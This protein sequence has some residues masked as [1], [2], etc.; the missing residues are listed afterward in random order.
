MAIKLNK[1][2]DEYLDTELDASVDS[3]FLES[4]DKIMDENPRLFDKLAKL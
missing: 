1:R 4:V 2:A 3:S